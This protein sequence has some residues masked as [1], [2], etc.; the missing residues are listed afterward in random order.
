MLLASSEELVYCIYS[1]QIIVVS[2]K[3]LLY[4]DM[5]FERGKDPKKAL[6][7]GLLKGIEVLIKY[8]PGISILDEEETRE[9]LMYENKNIWKYHPA[10]D[11]SGKET[12]FTAADFMRTNAIGKFAGCHICI[13]TMNGRYHVLKK[14][15][16]IPKDT[17]LPLDSTGPLEELYTIVRALGI[18]TDKP[19]RYSRSGSEYLT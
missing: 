17:P 10:M 4:C 18:K 2:T 19:G 12:G 13:G 5:N 8:K 7:I 9:H 16:S 6:D 1:S 15:P 14:V 11:E 3:F